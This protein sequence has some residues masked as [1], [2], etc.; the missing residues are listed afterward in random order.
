M[1]KLVEACFCLYLRLWELNFR[2]WLRQFSHL[3]GVFREELEE[4]ERDIPLHSKGQQTTKLQ[5]CC[6]CCYNISA[7][8]LLLFNIFKWW[9]TPLFLPGESHGQRSLVGYS[10]WGCKSQTWQRLNHYHHRKGKMTPVC[11]REHIKQGCFWA[12]PCSPVIHIT[13]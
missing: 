6:R 2:L 7:F 13:W 9:P 4:M 5:K 12:M 3:L 11:T 1:D 8:L 10:P